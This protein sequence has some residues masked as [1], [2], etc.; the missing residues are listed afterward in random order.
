MKRFF[1]VDVI[2]SYYQFQNLANAHMKD[3]PVNDVIWHRS[4]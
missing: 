1:N 4:I 2:T 3:S